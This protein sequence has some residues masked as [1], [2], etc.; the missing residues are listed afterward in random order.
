MYV[1]IA[2]ISIYH[3]HMYVHY[4]TEPFTINFIVNVR[5]S[6]DCLEIPKYA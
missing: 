1:S 2:S 4:N 6:I 3:M 5:N